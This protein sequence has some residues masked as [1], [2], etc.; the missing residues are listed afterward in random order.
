MHGRSLKKPTVGFEDDLPWVAS[1]TYRRFYFGLSEGYSPSARDEGAESAGLD[2]EKVG[3]RGVAFPSPELLLLE[4]E[5][6]GR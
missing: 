2:G 1:T 3:E 5:N 4:G 6:L